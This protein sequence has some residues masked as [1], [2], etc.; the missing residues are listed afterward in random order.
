[1]MKMDAIKRY[2][3]ARDVMDG[4]IATLDAIEE[5]QGETME[6]MAVTEK[7]IKEASISIRV[8]KGNIRRHISAM[9]KVIITELMALSGMEGEGINEDDG[10]P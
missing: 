3:E 1:M 9:D 8:I 7:V 6:D 2:K 4:L 10:R 5:I